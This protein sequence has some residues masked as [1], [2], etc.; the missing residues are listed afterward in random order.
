MRTM[1]PYRDDRGGRIH[2]L[3]LSNGEEWNLRKFDAGM[4]EW[5]YRIFRN[6][7]FFAMCDNREDADTLM[8]VMTQ[9]SG[10]IVLDELP[11]NKHWCE[12]KEIRNGVEFCH[13]HDAPISKGSAEKVPV[14]EY[15]VYL[16]LKNISSITRRKLALNDIGKE[17]DSFT[18]MGFELIDGDIIQVLRTLERE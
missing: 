15:H 4:G 16:P 1:T 9:R 6:G 11:P 13:F 2:G 14:Y 17:E 8:G 10:G 5:E 7:K 18:R 3:T 12:H